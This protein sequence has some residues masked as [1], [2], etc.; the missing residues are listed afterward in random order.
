[1]EFVHATA[2]T[3]RTVAARYQIALQWLRRNDYDPAGWWR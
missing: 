2:C 3:L 1:M